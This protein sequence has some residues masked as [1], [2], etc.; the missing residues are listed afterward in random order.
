MMKFMTL[1]GE[2]SHSLTFPITFPEI[3]WLGWNH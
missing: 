1:D 3:Q 2:H